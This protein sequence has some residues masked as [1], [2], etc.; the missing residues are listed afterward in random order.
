MNTTDETRRVWVLGDD[1]KRL[2][3]VKSKGDVLPECEGCP[4]CDE[5]DEFDLE[6][7]M[8]LGDEP[9]CSCVYCQQPI[10]KDDVTVP[11]T[12][13][14]TVKEGQ[15]EDYPLYGYNRMAHLDCLLADAR[16]KPEDE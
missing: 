9:W 10:K 14:G 16:R 13:W 7:P 4:G 3:E 12:S 15:T 11:M 2:V 8:L 5:D 1:G 6:D